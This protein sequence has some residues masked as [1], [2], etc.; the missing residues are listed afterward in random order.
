MNRL[1]GW[2][3]N[4]RP[5]SP[6]PMPSSSIEKV[7]VRCSC[8]SQGTAVR[9]GGAR[10]GH[11]AVRQ[12]ACGCPPHMQRGMTSA[13]ACGHASTHLQGVLDQAGGLVEQLRAAAIRAVA[14]LGLRGRG[15]VA[16]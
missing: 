10:A 8:C 13:L 4:P 15:Q 7:W 3:P 1:P 6:I 16:G 12:P 11:V 5:M 9:R 14:A 2:R